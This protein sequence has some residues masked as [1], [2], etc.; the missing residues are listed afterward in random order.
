LWVLPYLIL[1][2]AWAFTNPPGAAPDESDHLVKALAAARLDLGRPFEGSL[3]EDPI[4]VRNASIAR[5][6]SV[7]ARLAPDGYSC[8]AFQPTMTAACLAAAATPGQDGLVERVTPVGAYPV[9]LYVPIGLAANL[10]STPGEAFR[11]ARLAAL[12]MSCGLLYLAVWHA[13]RWLGRPSSLGIA[14]AM[15]PMAVFATASVSTSGIEITSAIAVTAVVLV[16]TRNPA[17]L[18]ATSTS[19]IL[20]SAGAALILSRQLGI[21]AMA[22]LSLVL[23]ARGGFPV[24]WGELRRGRPALILAAVAVLLSTVFLVGWERRFD[25]P[26]LTGQVSLAS[27]AAWTRQVPFHVESAIGRFGWLDTMLPV[28]ALYLWLAVT[29][30]VVGAAL[31]VARRADLATLVLAALWLGLVSLVT[32]SIVFYP[33]G[34]GLQGRHLLALYALIPCLATL[35]LLER[36]PPIGRQVQLRTT[37][38]IAAVVPLVQLLAWYANGR[39]YSVGEGGRWWFIPASEWSP[40]GGWVAWML[41]VVLATSMMVGLLLYAGYSAAPPRIRPQREDG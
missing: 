35:V 41:A 4:A 2:C 37:V 29:A 22:M 6:V 38:I 33:I 20:G 25:H 3:G 11:F 24:L 26:A 27:A 8:T 17:S 9:P 28:P 14:L 19:A 18:R 12:A 13:G 10:A 15:T 7:P 32:Y 34:A 23:L 31:L 5:V 21:V 39:R 1:G 36:P 40:P 30:C 16:S